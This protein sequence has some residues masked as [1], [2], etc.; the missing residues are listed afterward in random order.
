[1]SNKLVVMKA[2]LPDYNDITRHPANPYNTFIEEASLSEICT[3]SS[4]YNTR[5]CLI[6]D[7]RYSKDKNL[8]YLRIDPMS[9]QMNKGTNTDLATFCMAMENVMNI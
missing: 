2:T 5:L 9:R 3:V 6:Q 8:A 4:I 1:M 7:V